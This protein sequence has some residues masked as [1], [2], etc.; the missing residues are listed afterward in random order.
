M[1][2]LVVA[3]ASEARPLISRFK[4]EK[5]GGCWPIYQKPGL[6]LIVSGVGK[7]A[8]A[9]AT[10]YLFAKTVEAERDTDSP[11]AWLNVGVAGS[12]ERDLGR[13]FLAGRIEDHSSGRSWDP[14]P[15]RDTPFPSAPVMTVDKATENYEEEWI[16]EMEATGFY[17]AA[18]RLSRPGNIHCYKVI[19]DNRTS[20]LQ[21]VTAPRIEAL[22]ASRLDEITAIM[23]TMIGKSHLE[24]GNIT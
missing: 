24:G 9:A 23:E 10:G 8:S 1:I 17:S 4:L 12:G 14:A 13:G 3:L 21:K 15:L 20:P 2:R 22:I 6:S 19:S 5:A 16:Y 7:L 18:A 11:E